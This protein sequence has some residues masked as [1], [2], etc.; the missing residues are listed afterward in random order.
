MS[1]S[2]TG[3]HFYFIL[4]FKNEIKSLKNVLFYFILIMLLF[5]KWFLKILFLC[6]TQFI[7]I[8]IYSLIIIIF[9]LILNTLG[10]CSCISNFLART[11]SG[12]VIK[13]N[14]ALHSSDLKTGKFFRY[15]LHE[16]LY[17]N[18]ELPF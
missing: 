9:D 2:F 1:I 14:F 16:F 11:K 5:P 13:H 6:L 4:F 17:V 15:V 18:A 3:V 10:F 8:T 7:Q 12:K